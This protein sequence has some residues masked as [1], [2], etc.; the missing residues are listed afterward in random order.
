MR[1][2][3]VPVLILLVAFASWRLV[4]TSASLSSTSKMKVSAVS[5]AL[6]FKLNGDKDNSLDLNLGNV[7][8]GN[9]GKVDIT[10]NN[11]GDI[12][13]SLCVKG[14]SIP[15]GFTVQSP[16]MCGVNIDPN[17]SVR[18]EINW[19]LPLTAHN[20]GLASDF[21]FSY[22]FLLENGFKVTKIVI[23]KGTVDD[24]TDT[25]TPTETFTE[26]ST[27][28]PTPTD[29]LTPTATDTLDP[30]PATDT[31]DPP[32]ADTAT[33][34][35]TETPTQT[36]TD[37]L[38]PTA[39]ETPLPTATDTLVPTATDTPLPT[40]T[41]TLVPPPTDTPVPTDTVIPTDTVEPTSTP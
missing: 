11:I 4:T 5:A 39:T 24:P 32:P 41:D 37:T 6:N 27:E 2:I 12:S 26:T 25:P 22:S 35:P 18:F 15:P 34:V 17:G 10:V 33:P 30:P 21:Q 8:P 9:S 29:T 14:K 3:L 16:N 20:T 23:L 31:L 40:A 36:P 7:R 1:K 19:S 38:V 28:T 13:G